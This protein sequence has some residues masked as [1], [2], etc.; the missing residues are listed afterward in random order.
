MTYDN[1]RI[2]AASQGDNY[3]TSCFLD[4]PYFKENYNIV[5]I[6][7]SKLQTLDA[8]PKTMQ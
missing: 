2:I 4:Y 1:I 6:D 5:A 3:T 8:D 7:L